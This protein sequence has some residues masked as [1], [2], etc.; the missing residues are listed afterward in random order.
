MVNSLLIETSQIMSYV[1]IGVLVLVLVGSMILMNRRR[2]KQEKESQDLINA[3][4]PGNKVT[5]IGGI[6]GIVVEVDPEDDC[7]ILETGSEASGKSHIKFIRQ[8]IYQSDVTVDKN[9]SSKKGSE[10][11]EEGETAQIENVEA[12]DVAVEESDTAKKD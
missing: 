4:K 3:V 1:L 7:I 5:T 11:Q 8:A 12:G 2:A 6:V 9:K 10:S